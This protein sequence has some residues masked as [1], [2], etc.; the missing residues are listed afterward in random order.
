MDL[1]A[2]R[3]TPLKTLRVMFHAGALVNRQIN[4]QNAQTVIKRTD[5]PMG[6]KIKLLL[7]N[8]INCFE[9][10]SLRAGGRSD[11]SLH[12]KHILAALIYRSRK[13]AF[14]LSSASEKC[15]DLEGIRKVLRSK[16]PLLAK[17]T[18]YLAF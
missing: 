2:D 12:R 5:A 1:M 3:R 4:S 14:L 6:V 8:G 10:A 15:L 18:E 17:I 11:K 13:F 16:S 7:Q 9:V